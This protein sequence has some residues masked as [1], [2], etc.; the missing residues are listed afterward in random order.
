MSWAWAFILI[1]FWQPIAMTLMAAYHKFIK[2]DPYE[3]GIY[4]GDMKA[5]FLL[6]FDLLKPRKLN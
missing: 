3:M 5:W 6:L 4:W 2:K 1:L